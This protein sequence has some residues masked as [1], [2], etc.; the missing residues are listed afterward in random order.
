MSFHKFIPETLL[1]LGIVHSYV[2]ATA[3]SLEM[4]LNM[5]EIR[6]FQ[7]TETPPTSQK[8][9]NIRSFPNILEISSRAYI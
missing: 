1:Y 3:Y 8:L 4:S 5:L 9:D 7:Y 2:Y 6:P